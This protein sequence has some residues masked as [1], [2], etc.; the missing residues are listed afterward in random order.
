MPKVNAAN[1]PAWLRNGYKLFSPVNPDDL[2]SK[3][4]GS[5]S[6]MNH[7]GT[8]ASNLPGD[9]RAMIVSWSHEQD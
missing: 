2:I 6:A 1:W 8:Q 4:D 7:G 3:L 9:I 5:G